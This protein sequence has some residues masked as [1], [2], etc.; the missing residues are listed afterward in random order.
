MSDLQSV[1][2]HRLHRLLVQVADLAPEALAGAPGHLQDLRPYLLGDLLPGPLVDDRGAGERRPLEVGHVRGEGEPLE[3]QRGKGRRVEGVDQARLQA[4]KDVHH[5]NRHGT[6]PRFLI[7]LREGDVPGADIQLHRLHFRGMRERLP[8]EEVDPSRV[9]PVE[10]DES[11]LLEAL[12]QQRGE[13]VADVVELLL[14]GV[15]HRHVQAVEGTVEEGKS[16]ARDRRGLQLPHP[17]LSEHRVLVPYHSSGI[18]AQDDRSAGDLF[19]FPP[20]LQQDAVPRRPLR[21][22]GRHLD[23]RGPGVRRGAERDEE[24]QNRGSRRPTP[25][26]DHPPSL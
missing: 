1:I 9:P 25:E 5:R 26:R 23:H 4:G 12:L 17:H 2:H 8:C 19:P 15:H 10:D 20:H 11:L 14:G 24:Q 21:G 7:Q 18:D 22:E 16:H 6:E 3:G 13:T